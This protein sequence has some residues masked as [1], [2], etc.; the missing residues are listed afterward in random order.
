MREIKFRG[1]D[2]KKMFPCWPCTP[3][4]DVVIKGFIDNFLSVYLPA[5][6]QGMHIYDKVEEI[7]QYTGLKDKNGK[8]AYEKDYDDDGNMIDWCERCCGYQFFQID[9][10]SKD[11]IF[12]HNCEG[13]F[14]LQD[15]IDDFKITG[16]LYER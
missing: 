1:W 13:N 6:H 14:M 8:E 5:G 12:C 3:N 4:G 9:E 10:P 7:M 15:H 11:I 16:N 2:G